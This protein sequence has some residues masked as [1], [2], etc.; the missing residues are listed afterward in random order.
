MVHRAAVLNEAGTCIM[1]S[2]VFFCKFLQ[3]KS[4]IL[5][6]HGSDSSRR[7]LVVTIRHLVV[8]AITA[9]WQVRVLQLFSLFSH[10]ERQPDNANGIVWAVVVLY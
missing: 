2:Y 1:N 5:G 8:R 7:E 3:L 6:S 9:A 10:D 4:E